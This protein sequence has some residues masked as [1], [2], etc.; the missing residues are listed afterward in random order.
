MSKYLKFVVA[1]LAAVAMA[2]PAFA[3][4]ADVKGFFQTRGIAYDNVLDMNDDADDNA[5]GVD[6]RFR[7]FTNAALNENVKA[8]FGIEIDNTWGRKNVSPTTLTD[9]G[10]DTVSIPA[11]GKQVGTMGTDAKAEIEIKHVYLDFNIPELNTNVKAGSQYFSLGRGLIIA[12]DAAGLA[13]RIADPFIH[14][15]SIGLYWVKAQE[16]NINDDSA[17]ADYYHLQYDMKLADWKLAPYVGWFD[18]V[19]DADT[20]F[21]GADLDGKLGPLGLALTALFNDWDNGAGTTGDSFA[22]WGKGTYKIQNTALSLEAAWYGDEDRAGGQLKSLSQGGATG[23]YNNFAEIIT[24]G[25]FDGRGEVGNSFRGPVAPYTTN[26]AY[27][28]AGAEQSYFEGKDKVSLYYIFAQEAADTPTATGKI[29]ART[30]GH[31]VNAYYD[32]QI[33]KGLTFT[34]AGAYLLADDDI[35]AAGKTTADDAWKLGTALTYTF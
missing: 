25:R 24:G 21:I 3:V 8:V 9:S 10:G 33:L 22:L 26:Y 31:E 35:A 1:T 5:R 7:L 19:D 12:D 11:P 32:H 18:E 6:Q 16:G 2:T 15:N 30:F 17:D 13:V 27:V 34:L 4:T 20:L 23:A 14:D 29:D 28:K